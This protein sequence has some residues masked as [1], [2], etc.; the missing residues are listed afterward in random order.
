MS[1]QNEF[2]VQRVVAAMKSELNIDNPGSIEEKHARELAEYTVQLARVQADL[3]AAI[4]ARD[5]AVSELAANIAYQQEALTRAAAA[6]ASGDQTQLQAVLEFA[7]AS[8]AEKARLKKLEKA[9]QLKAEAAALEAEA[10]SL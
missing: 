6:I 7:G 5:S 1:L 3:D 10:Q 9:A 8:F 4:I 2:D